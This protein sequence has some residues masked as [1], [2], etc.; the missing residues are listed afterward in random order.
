MVMESAHHPSMA[1]EE[2]TNEL[3]DFSGLE[4]VGL[5]NEMGRKCIQVPSTTSLTSPSQQQ[6]QQPQPDSTES[7][8]LLVS[9]KMPPSNAPGTPPDTPPGDGHPLSPHYP[10]HQ[11]LSNSSM[12][13]LD[14]ACQKITPDT[15][16]M[17]AMPWQ[18]MLSRS[19]HSNGFLGHEGPLDLRP[20]GG[21]EMES[22]W[23]LPPNQ[24]RRAEYIELQNNP[25]A[26]LAMNQR[27]LQGMINGHM[28]PN[29]SHGIHHPL[30]GHPSQLS[31]TQ[32][33]PQHMQGRH[34]GPQAVHLPSPVVSNHSVNPSYPSMSVSHHING[35]HNNHHPG[36]N[37]QSS[38]NSSGSSC[39]NSSN[40]TN[41]NNQ[42]S[43]NTRGQNNQNH[44]NLGSADDI[45]SDDLLI[46][47]SV[48]EL[49]K[50]LHGC[51]RDEIQRLKQKRRTLKNRGYAQNCRTKR[52]AHRHELESCN[53]KLQNELNRTRREHDAA[54]QRISVLENQ[55][56]VFTSSASG[57]SHFPPPFMSHPSHPPQHVN[58]HQSPLPSDRVVSTTTPNAPSTHETGNNCQT[59]DSLSSGSSG[60]SPS[61]P[62][63]YSYNM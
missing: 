54:L 4:D 28:L 51:P 22:H 35:S 39:N 41:A 21:S 25:N 36:Q 58:L 5:K 9:R 46:R 48:R 50:K 18:G 32:H 14:P 7:L 2:Y 15:D 6:H 19:F 20:S 60:G 63:E 24:L 57:L 62:S 43:H 23:P 47:L 38:S 44:S 42:H 16:P 59:R 29:A 52:L 49:N 55:L 3:L 61:S 40:S 31:P 12:S 37:S 33:F 34:P 56:A 17:H 1:G 8:H 45:L 27:M 26:H 11:P 10:V 13:V 30:A 53:R